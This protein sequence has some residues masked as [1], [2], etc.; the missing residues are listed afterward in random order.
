MVLRCTARPAFRRSPC[1]SESA[2]GKE[3]ADEN[4]RFDRVCAA[5]R[6]WDERLRLPAHWLP[7]A[8]HLRPRGRIVALHTMTRRGSAFS[9][10]ASR[11]RGPMI[12]FAPP[13]P[14]LPAQALNKWRQAL[15]H[16]Y[17]DNLIGLPPVLVNIFQGLSIQSNTK[18]AVVSS[19]E[20][21]SGLE[22]P[23][24]GLEP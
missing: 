17:E 18:T 11:F 13:P 5:M 21:C 10:R 3:D 14:S 8:A 15:K 1:A 2:S 20:P 7:C 22:M 24:H 4:G 6:G 23:T 16:V 9:E 12:F 19:L